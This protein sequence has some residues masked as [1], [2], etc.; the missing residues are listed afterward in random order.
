MSDDNYI[1]IVSGIAEGDIVYVPQV[2]HESSGEEG[3]MGMM[4]GGM[5]GM[6]GGEMGGMPAGGGGMLPLVAAEACPPAVVAVC[7]P[8]VA[9]AVCRD[10][11][12]TGDNRNTAD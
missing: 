2:M 3:E 11:Y 6:S 10:E 1:E 8:V 4:P 7:L 12:A 9:E 5:G